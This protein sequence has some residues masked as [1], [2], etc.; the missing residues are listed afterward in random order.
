MIIVQ[1]LSTVDVEIEFDFRSLG[2]C[3]CG[4]KR[5]LEQKCMGRNLGVG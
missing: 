5:V 1:V 4:G 2:K 3:A